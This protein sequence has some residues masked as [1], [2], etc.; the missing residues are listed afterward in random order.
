MAD[1]KE[2]DYWPVVETAPVPVHRRITIDGKTT[3]LFSMH[4]GTGDHEGLEF[5]FV[6][7]RGGQLSMC[8]TNAPQG[9]DG[10][11]GDYYIDI[12]DLVPLVVGLEKAR[13]A[14][15]KKE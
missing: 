11:E 12:R 10:S 6:F 2:P 15:I 3:M 4:G 7:G 13:R 14:A 5:H 1:E 9:A 8:F